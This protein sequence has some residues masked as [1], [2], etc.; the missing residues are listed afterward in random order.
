MAAKQGL[1]DKDIAWD[2]PY[3]SEKDNERKN[4]Q[5]PLEIEKLLEV[6][7]QRRAKHY[8]PLAILLAVE[9]GCSTQEDLSLK[10]ADVDL[11]KN[12]ITSTGP[13]MA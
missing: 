9:H 12:H 5:K 1:I 3:L 11:A 4:A 13:R 2:I 6:A 10:W 7:R 8:L